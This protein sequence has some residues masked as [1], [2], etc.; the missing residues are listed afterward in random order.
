MGNRNQEIKLNVSKSLVTPMW[1]FAVLPGFV[2]DAKT[3]VK[4]MEMVS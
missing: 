4:D 2:K 1:S 3:I